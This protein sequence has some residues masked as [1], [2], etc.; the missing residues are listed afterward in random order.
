MI[1]FS[2]IDKRTSRE[3]KN[4]P[5]SDQNPQPLRKIILPWRKSGQK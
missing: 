2:Q 1:I 5:A 4:L 3:P